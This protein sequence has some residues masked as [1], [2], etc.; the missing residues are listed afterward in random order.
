MYIIPHECIFINAQVQIRTQ[1]TA[2]HINQSAFYALT[3]QIKPIYDQCFNIFL[4][5][6]HNL[7]W[8][9]KIIDSSQ[10]KIIA[11]CV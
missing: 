3:T 4:C 6:I 9:F 7:G 1:T 11:F 2:T 10:Y 5:N 8:D